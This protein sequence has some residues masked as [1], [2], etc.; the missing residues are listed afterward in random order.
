MKGLQAPARSRDHVSHQ[1]G[2]DRPSATK[3][4]LQRAQDLFVVPIE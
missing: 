3:L 4:L 2:R 1:F